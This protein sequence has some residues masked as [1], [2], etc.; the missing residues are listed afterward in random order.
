MQLYDPTLRLFYCIYLGRARRDF[1][2]DA[3]LSGDKT[4]I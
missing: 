3:Q 1:P 2:K 4:T